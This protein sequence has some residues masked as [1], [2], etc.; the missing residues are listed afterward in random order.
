MRVRLLLPL[1]VLACE[2]TAPA[3][4]TGADVAVGGLETLRLFSEA[5]LDFAPLTGHPTLTSVSADD[6]PVLDLMPLATMPQLVALSFNGSG[7]TDLVGLTGASGLQF[8]SVDDNSLTD[9]AGLEGKPLLVDLSAS[10]NQIADIGALSDATGLIE[11]NLADNAITDVSPLAN[12]AGLQ[13]LNLQ[14]NPLSGLDSL[15]GLGAL[16]RLVVARCGLTGLPAISPDTLTWLDA[17]DNKIV[18]VSPLAGHKVLQSAA[19]NKNAI[20]SVTPLADAP[21]VLAGCISLGL[22]EN[23]LDM[24][25]LDV[26]L[27]AMCAPDNYINWDGGECSPDGFRCGVSDP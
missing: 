17:Y 18:D 23:P 15:A 7:L 27:P 9:L 22:S 20:V 8:L 5:V 13:E 25:S 11:V 14:T 10:D 21:W 12:A 2:P 3:T 26:A 19:L 4:E 24:A 16:T 6:T 1:V